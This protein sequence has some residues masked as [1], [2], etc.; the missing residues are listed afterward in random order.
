MKPAAMV[1]V[2]KKSLSARADVLAGASAHKE[3]LAAR[4]AAE[5]DRLAVDENLKAWVLG[6]FGA[7]SSEAGEFGF[8]A[9]KAP[10]VTAATRAHAVEQNKAT[11]AARGTVGKKQKADANPRAPV[12]DSIELRVV[13]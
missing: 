10:T 6:R 13:A 8:A 2:Y 1:K 5:G 3:A 9:R 11:R 7:N 4:D 12:D